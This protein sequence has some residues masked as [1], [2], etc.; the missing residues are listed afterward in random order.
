MRLTY[1]YLVGLLTV[2]LICLLSFAPVKKN[3]IDGVWKKLS[4]TNVNGEHQNWMRTKYKFISGNRFAWLDFDEKTGRVYGGGGGTFTLK[5]N[6]YIE[7]LE[8][9]MADS[10]AIG[11]SIVF[12]LRLDGDKWYHKGNWPYSGGEI[13]IDEGMGAREV[14]YSL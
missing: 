6:V 14:M 5:K 13:R 2:S 11:D 1:Q 10:N 8:Y 3:K 12:S 9:Y 4:Y 7:Y